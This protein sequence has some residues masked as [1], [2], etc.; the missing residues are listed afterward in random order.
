MFLDGNKLAESAMFSEIEPFGS[1]IFF[2]AFIGL[3]AP[4]RPVGPTFN[5]AIITQSG[6]RRPLV[7]FDV[8][9]T[10]IYLKIVSVLLIS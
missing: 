2:Y 9:K 7:I 6:D 8:N 10:C 5:L 1:Y 4:P 3:L